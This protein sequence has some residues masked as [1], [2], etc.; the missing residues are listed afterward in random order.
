MILLLTI[1]IFLQGIIFLF[2]IYLEIH[3]IFLLSLFYS[4][5]LFRSH[6]IYVGISVCS[7][8]LSNMKKVMCSGLYVL[9]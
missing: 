2:T 3:N 7:K 4:F 8:G 5:L 9:L 1:G 6:R